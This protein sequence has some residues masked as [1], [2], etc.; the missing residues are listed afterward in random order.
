M[1]GSRLRFPTVAFLGWL[2]PRGITPLITAI[3]VGRE[4]DLPNIDAISNLVVIT[5][6]CS[7]VLHGLTPWPGSQR[8]GRWI[9]DVG[10]G[11]LTRYEERTAPT[12]EP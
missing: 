7:V 8:Y 5:V 2:E 3:L 1:T 4:F 11:P 6:A 12:T 9:A 10:P